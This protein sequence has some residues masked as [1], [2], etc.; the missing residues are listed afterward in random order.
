MPQSLPDPCQTGHAGGARQVAVGDERFNARIAARVEDR[1]GALAMLG[2]WRAV[3]QM[4]RDGRSSLHGANCGSHR[5]ALV[6]RVFEN[7]TVTDT[8][9]RP[10]YGR[11]SA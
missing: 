6:E 8:V 1:A 2:P 3:T 7:Q 11:K 4:L 10:C 9:Q 5:I